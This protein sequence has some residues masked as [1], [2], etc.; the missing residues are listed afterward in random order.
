MSEQKSYQIKTSAESLH[1]INN[2]L[3]K[4]VKAMEETNRLLLE[5]VSKMG[6]SSIKGNLHS[7]AP[8]QPTYAP[9]ANDPF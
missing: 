4:V 8:Q 2:S 5:A 7:N 9:H 6:I 3:G 1:W